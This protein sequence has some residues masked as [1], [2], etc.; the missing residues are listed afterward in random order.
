MFLSGR[1]FSCGF[2]RGGI[3]MGSAGAGQSSLWSPA[4]PA[5]VIHSFGVPFDL[6]DVVYRFFVSPLWNIG[7][8][9]LDA[10]PNAWIKRLGAGY[11]LSAQQRSASGVVAGE[12]K[13]SSVR[14]HGLGLPL[15]PQFA[16]VVDSRG[17]VPL[18]FIN[19]N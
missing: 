19:G 1:S 10:R 3:S 5:L 17:N 9:R 8:H 4:D 18:G 2:K 13:A 6:F 15:V 14:L 16:V 7:G 11:L 12:H